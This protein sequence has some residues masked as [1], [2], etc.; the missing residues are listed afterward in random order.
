VCGI[1]TEQDAERRHIKTALCVVVQS[2]MFISLQ[3]RQLLDER[4]TLSTLPLSAVLL[5][6]AAG[7]RQLSGNE[8][9]CFCN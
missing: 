1:T 4:T 8:A 2:P 9:G 3:G 5:R 7:L 6:S